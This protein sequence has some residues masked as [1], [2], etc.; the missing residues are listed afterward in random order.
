MTTALTGR[1]A[2]LAT[3]P[4]AKRSPATSSKV[5]R[6]SREG[7]GLASSRRSNTYHIPQSTQGIVTALLATLGGGHD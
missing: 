1:D 2:D 3:G 5:S 6:A 7:V 4:P